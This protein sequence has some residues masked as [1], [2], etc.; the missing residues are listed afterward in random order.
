MI[1]RLGISLGGLIGLLVLE[2]FAVWLNNH[3]TV[4]DTPVSS[5]GWWMGLVLSLCLIGLVGLILFAISAGVVTW[6]KWVKGK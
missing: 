2:F 5:V 1:K 3:W 4:P 6:A